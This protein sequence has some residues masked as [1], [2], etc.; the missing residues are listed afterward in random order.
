[1]DPTAAYGELLGISEF[2]RTAFDAIGYDMV[3]EPTSGMA[4]IVFACVLLVRRR[5]GALNSLH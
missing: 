5:R 2:D 4:L 1:M 3:P